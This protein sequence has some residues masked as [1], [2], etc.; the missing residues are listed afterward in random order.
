MPAHSAVQL[1]R[2]PFTVPLEVHKYQEPKNLK[3]GMQISEVGGIPKQGMT[4]LRTSARRALGQGAG[5]RRSAPLVL[6]AHGGPAA[7]PQVSA[8]LST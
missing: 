8:D 7:D 4:K 1:S 3:P 6:M 2:P 5:L